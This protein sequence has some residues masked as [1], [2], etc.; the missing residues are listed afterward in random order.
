MAPL[1]VIS[2]LLLYP[3]KR[4]PCGEHIADYGRQAASGSPRYKVCAESVGDF[5]TDR[6]RRTI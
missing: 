1:L 3:S 4:N 6:E 2:F 5:G